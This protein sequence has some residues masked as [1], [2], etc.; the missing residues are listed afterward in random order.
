MP[1]IDILGS[2]RIDNRD[3][4]FPQAVQLPDGDIL[5]SFSVKKVRKPWSGLQIG[6]GPNLEG[7]ATRGGR[8]PSES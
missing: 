2:G 5:C 1:N 3:S 8:S 7:G 6:P 4:A